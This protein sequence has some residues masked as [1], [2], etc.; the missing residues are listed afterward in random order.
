MATPP[1]RIQGIQKAEAESKKRSEKC[2]KMKTER[3]FLLRKQYNEQWPAM[4]MDIIV[5]MM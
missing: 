2:K 1:S 3:D 5:I 4:S